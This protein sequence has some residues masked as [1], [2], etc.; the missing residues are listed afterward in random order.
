MTE[1]RVMCFDD[2]EDLLEVIRTILS[3]AKINVQLYS[4]TEGYLEKISTFQPDVIML[5]VMFAKEKTDGFE[6]CRCIRKDPRFEK[7]PIV[8]LTAIN[9]YYPC[10]FEPHPEFLPCDYFLDKPIDPEKLL[11]ILG[12]AFNGESIKKE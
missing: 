5:D 4:R 12:K 8:M 2:D 11:E 9:D 1:K 6:L 3:Q 10:N 7:L